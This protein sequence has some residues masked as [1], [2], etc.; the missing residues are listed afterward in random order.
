MSNDLPRNLY[1]G[2]EDWLAAKPGITDQDLAHVRNQRHQLVGHVAHK[3]EKLLAAVRTLRDFDTTGNATTALDHIEAVRDDLQKLT[4]NL[5]TDVED[6]EARYDQHSTPE[7]PAAAVE[8]TPQAPAAAG[9]H[10]R[11]EGTPG[12]SPAQVAA[13]I[14][15]ALV[16]RA[17][18]KRLVVR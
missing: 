9:P 10:V 11:L 3:A 16:D 5:V 14:N 8:P 12:P 18:A 4:T 7:T 13:R 1:F 15:A 6:A 17:A 2:A